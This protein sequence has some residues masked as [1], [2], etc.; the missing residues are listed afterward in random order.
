MTIIVIIS[1]IYLCMSLVTGLFGL[2]LLA[3]ARSTN[4]IFSINFGD[5][6]GSFVAWAALWP[7]FLVYF[8]YLAFTSQKLPGD[9]T[10]GKH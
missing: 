9:G 7:G 4:N 1:I 3:R 6:L 5:I 8:I 10:T 2:V